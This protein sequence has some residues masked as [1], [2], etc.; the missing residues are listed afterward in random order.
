M[1]FDSDILD[2]YFTTDNR[3]TKHHLS[4]F[5]HFVR[6]DLNTIITDN[7]VRYR[8]K[9]AN[10]GSYV[11]G[12]ISF[13]EVSVEKP[14]YVDNT[15]EIR[16]IF[17][18]RCRN[19]NSTY[20]MNI[21]ASYTFKIWK[22]EGRNAT[23]TIVFNYTPLEPMLLGQ[24]PCMVKSE[25]CN[26]HNL[27]EDD[28]QALEE[29]IYEKGGY[30]IINGIEYIILPHEHKTDNKIY[31]N[32]DEKGGK[33]SYS[34][35]GSFK[36][37]NEYSYPHYTDVTINS[38]DEILIS[39]SVSKANKH[40]FPLSVFYR[41]LGVV[42]DKEIY[43]LIVAD[44]DSESSLISI[45]KVSIL[46]KI[47]DV[48]TQRDALLYMG[49][50]IRSSSY[51][52]K[53]DSD[54]DTI[55]YVQYKILRNELFRHIGGIDKLEE[56]KVFLSGM[57]R[58]CIH[59][60]LGYLLPYD[61]HDYGNKRIHTSGILYGQL[62]RHTF[63]QLT[64]NDLKRN[65]NKELNKYSPTRKYE[66]F[67]SQHFNTKGLSNMNRN[68][69]TGE[70]P[71]GRIKGYNVKVGVAIAFN[72][73]SGIDPIASTQKIVR[74]QKKK[75]E[76]ESLQIPA[77]KLHQTH[78]GYIDP[79]DTPDGKL[80]GKLK[81]KTIMSDLTNYI[82]ESIVLRFIIANNVISGL[83]MSLSS[84]SY[85]DIPLYG[86]LVV[87]GRWRYVCPFEDLRRIYT[88]FLRARRSGEIH[89]LISIIYNI[90]EGAVYIYTDAGRFIRALIVV[91]RIAG[92]KGDSISSGN[93][94]SRSRMT[95][96][97]K[98][99]LAKKE[100]DW[101]WLNDNGIIE[102]VSMH[103]EQYSL[104]VALH[105]RMIAKN[106]QE[107][108]THCE[109]TPLAI[110]AATS[111]SIALLNSNQAPRNNFQNQMQKQSAGTFAPNYNKRMDTEGMVYTSAQVPLVPSRMDTYTNIANLPSG[112]NL[113]TAI[114]VYS[115]FNIEDG[116]IINKQS[117][118]NG[119]FD[120]FVYKVVTDI[121]S[122]TNEIFMK[123][124][125]NNTD[126]YKYF[127]S[128]ANINEKGEPIIGRLVKKGDIIIGKVRR[129]PKSK[130]E[131]SFNKYEFQDKSKMMTGH[132]SGRIERVIRSYNVNGNAIIKVKIR[133]LKTFEVG[134]KIATVSAQKGVN[135]LTMD[136]EDMPFTG[137]GMMPT[138]LFNSHGLITRMTISQIIGMAYSQIAVDRGMHMDGTPFR[139]I[140]I[141]GGI[142]KTLHAMGHKN[143]GKHVMYNGIT[144]KRM[145]TP[146]YMTPLYYQ[147]LKH[148]VSTKVH[149]RDTGHFNRI[150]KQP[151]RG[152]KSGGAFKISHMMKDA[153]LAHG[154]NSIIR[155]K[156]FDHSD[157]FM[158]YIS[159][160][161]GHLC[162]GNKFKSIYM[163]NARNLK[164]SRVYLPWVFIM[165]YY[166]IQT[167]GINMEFILS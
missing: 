118:D 160:D 33:T 92:P 3:F 70:W 19:I 125:E 129:I 123:P 22:T 59:M 66:K 51:H 65:L 101:N 100:I 8:T 112:T 157:G 12:E 27:P 109:I 50:K 106:P 29:D 139:E 47:P 93:I 167:T 137:S 90:S 78:W 75:G 10:D 77:R 55:E 91:D 98:E 61:T 111:C 18:N 87:N 37:T 108:F 9:S 153:F 63:R 79:Y 135:S 85:R 143:Y 161:T 21:K 39:V 133:M 164:I 165:I 80:I 71:A 45:L 14:R 97:I 128:Y 6:N 110:L 46:N 166:L 138:I 25:Y 115:G 96:R 94:I 114:N 30:F 144:G 122:T 148:M 43:D 83:I 147:R 35:W 60:R 134:D 20:E 28:I 48:V 23:E 149:A 117:V 15:D 119:V 154:V 150:T 127:S 145:E 156:F 49:K 88:E 36:L 140:D 16:P 42:T 44:E 54:D 64:D 58:T 34:V 163:D 82:D 52:Q 126:Q 103:E 72:R 7:P 74:S 105:D 132:T 102:W 1:S 26:L 5:N 151:P 121:L 4:S 131:K 158:C 81:S 142:M 130:R 89:R 155:E 24:I 67:M 120:L 41:A 2:T 68:I 141:N 95:R 146:I 162:V 124:S 56:K 104:R 17:P 11:R 62:F 116:V 107:I 13:R 31:R 32:I 40:Q 136:A 38:N 69:N 99:R 159:E 76:E 53:Y 113:L 84:M 152:K 73:R 86:K 57:V